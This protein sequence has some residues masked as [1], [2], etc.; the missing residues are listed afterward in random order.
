MANG[1]T[2]TSSYRHWFARGGELQTEDGETRTIGV[3]PLVVGRNEAADVVIDDP[4]V[5]ALHCELRATAA[6]IAIRDLGSKNG[7]RVGV[8]SI[9]NACFTGPAEI[10]VGS[11]RLRVSPAG[12]E[13]VATGN[14]ERFGSLVGRSPATRRL[15]DALGRLASTSLSV[16]VVGETGTGKELVAK[17][18]HDSS[19]RMN[20]PFVVLDCGSIPGPL[21]ESLLFGHERGAF[22]GATDRRV[23]ALQE[24]S[25]GTLFLDELGELPIELQ[26][27]LLRALAEQKVQRVGGR[28][29]EAIDVRVV[30]A[31]RRDLRSE[32][33]AGRFRSDLYFRIAQYLLELPPLRERM[34]DLAIL[35]DEICNRAG[36]PASSN[37][38]LAWVESRLP[39]YDWPGNVREL[40]N[41]VA[42]AA[43]FANDPTAIDDAYS[44]QRGDQRTPRVP[45]AQ[46]P[47]TA[48]SNAKRDAIDAFERDYLRDLSARSGGVV[49]E[50]SRQSGLERHRVRAFLRKYGLYDGD[51]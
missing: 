32:M 25:G 31:T 15:F 21:A 28:G 46:R 49:R 43:S 12:P 1:G 22:T 20:G 14:R 51:R 5:S 11:S 8:V 24:A 3:D 44:A 40:V 16:L 9:H 37:G 4:E 36:Y 47:L 38:V 10:S 23:G 41:T 27:K 30:A 50:M 39:H 42:V 18:L 7:T 29:Y 33:N 48:F 35:V 26:P 6:G 13:R 17:A 34:G 19:A 2:A 45:D